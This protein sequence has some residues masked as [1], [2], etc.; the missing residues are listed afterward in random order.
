MEPSPEK[1]ARPNP[2]LGPLIAVSILSVAAVGTAGVLWASHGHQHTPIPAAPA[3]VAAAKEPAA[4]PTK[5]APTSRFDAVAGHLDKGGT[6]YLYLD[7]AQ[8]LA[9][10]GK[11]VDT[12][13]QLAL[14]APNS[15]P[16]P[17]SRDSV[18][19]GFTIINDLITKSGLEEIS[20]VGASSISVEPK[21]YLN[22]MFIHHA[23]DKA[24]G[25][26]WS[27][28]GK[29]PHHL[30]LIDFLPL[31]TAL[32]TSSDLDLAD[33]LAGLREEIGKSGV[34]NAT[35]N[36]DLFVGQFATNF[37]MPLEDLLK[38]LNGSL[39]LVLT[40]DQSK[41]ISLPIDKSGQPTTFPTPRVA[42]LLRV[43]DDRIFGLID[44]ALTGAPGLQKNDTPELRTRV[45]PVP[46]PTEAWLTPTVAQW[47]GGY[48][49]IASN[50]SIIKDMLEAQKTGHG[51]KSMPQFA[52]L[53]AG[54][55]EEGNGVQIITPLLGD[56][57]R[58]L[59]HEAM[60]GQPGV[61]PDQTAFMEKVF[62]Q[63]SDPMS[64]CSISTHLPDGWLMA[65]KGTKSTNMM[66]GPGMIVPAAIAAGVALPVFGEAQENAKATK[67]LSNARQLVTGCKL[68]AV[69]HQ[70]QFPPNLDAL[71]PDYMATKTPFASPFLPADPVG[72]TYHPD[73]KDSD[74][75]TTIL[76]EDK[77]SPKHLR[78]VA[79]IDGSGEV[80]H[81]PKTAVP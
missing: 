1:N 22:K 28:F 65:S 45:M 6:F 11:Q 50:E 12:F 38:S 30:D 35:Q 32:A 48:L 61:T 39:G 73:H 72:Y 64:I 29:A 41:P 81:L 44:K 54:L 74:P 80:I 4:A 67:S 8:W 56:T 66:L 23:T 57:L 34:P 78:V 40:L 46:G 18:N 26:L 55:P 10:L 16:D 51:L 31:D 60:K 5:T 27:A 43:K 59:Q 76:I 42:L 75:G 49:L 2:L 21:I 68:Y 17:A 77:F 53:R 36:F 3:P 15:S 13:R 20:A 25:F 33:T 24:D 47:S 69:D 71:V 52:S 19:T 7:T 70:G 9:G 79:R 14:M 58:V 37:G 63:S 62:G